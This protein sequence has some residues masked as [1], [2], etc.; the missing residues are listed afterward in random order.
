MSFLSKQRFF[1]CPKCG[2]KLK[3]MAYQERDRLTCLGCSYIL[4]ENPI[5]G[6]AA[7]VLNNER[8]ILLGRRKTGYYSQLWCIPCG[9]LEYDEDVYAGVR[10]E[11]KEETNLD[12]EL[13]SLFTVQSNFHDPECHT[14]GIWFLAQ[15]TGGKM[16]AG[17]DLDQLGYFDLD[18]PPALAFPSDEVVL[19]LLNSGSNSTESLN[20]IN[21]QLP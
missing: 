16:L 4:Y 1:Y 20:T 10:R 11:F 6:V 7:I 3:Y 17:D 21:K 13:L 15:I 19:N 18:N 12:I 2:Y 5:V 9:Y 8:Q 14:V